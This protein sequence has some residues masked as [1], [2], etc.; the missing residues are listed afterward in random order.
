MKQSCLCTRDVLHL[1]LHSSNKRVSSDSAKIIDF[2]KATLIKFLITFRLEKNERA[3]YNEKYKQIDDELRNQRGSQTSFC[4]HVYRLFRLIGYIADKC[5]VSFSETKF[6]AT[7]SKLL[8]T[9]RHSKFLDSSQPWFNWVTCLNVFV[10]LSSFFGILMEISYCL[11]CFKVKLTC[12][13]RFQH[14]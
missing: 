7:L 8:C 14:H 2:V 11:N 5:C 13:H 6:D 4:S 1:D 9:A 3:E 10:Y 12:S